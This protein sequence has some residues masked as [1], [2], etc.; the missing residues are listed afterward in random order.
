M[1]V[2]CEAEGMR[3]QPERVM[4]YYELGWGG[5]FSVHEGEPDELTV[6]FTLLT[7]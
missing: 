1:L 6:G 3:S 2:T 4:R 5:T 7:A